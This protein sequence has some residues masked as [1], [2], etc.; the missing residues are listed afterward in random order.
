MAQFTYELGVIYCGLVAC[1]LLF[2][3]FQRY[4]RQTVSYFVC[5]LSY[6]AASAYDLY[7]LGI[8]PKQPAE[9]NAAVASGLTEVF[10]KLPEVIG[11]TLF[12]LCFWFGGI[13]F[14]QVLNLTVD[15]RTRID[16]LR[17]G[18]WLSEWLSWLPDLLDYNQSQFVSFFYVDPLG[19]I[20]FAINFS[21]V[22]V[23]LYLAARIIS[24][25][26]S[27][28]LQTGRGPVSRTAAIPMLLLI[29]YAAIIAFGRIEPRGIH[30][31]GNNLYYA[32]TAHFFLLASGILLFRQRMTKKRKVSKLTHRQ[33][34]SSALATLCFSNIV[35]VMQLTHHMRYEYSEP[36]QA[37]ISK[38]AE[39]IG[40]YE[41]DERFIFSL[42]GDCEISQTL[43]WL[44]GAHIRRNTNWQP[45]FNYLDALF[46]EH[47]ANVA[48]NSGNA[49]VDARKVR[50]SCPE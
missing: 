31:L 40:T 2:E 10:L 29:A 50:L 8:W 23:T 35:A 32:Y 20:V 47:S 46:P 38:V 9:Q 7:R 34:L 21:V 25:P 41:K 39:M 42:Q 45:P 5:A 13:F 24:L 18:E 30:T 22:A 27:D 49:I 3:S 33:L 17:I 1:F 4:W 43:E 11:L 12:Q 26:T 19:G 14:P 37:L 28:R 6:P 15:G 16:G 36:R 48:V 44:E